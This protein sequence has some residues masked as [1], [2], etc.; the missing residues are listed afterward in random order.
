MRT[1]SVQTRKSKKISSRS[2]QKSHRLLQTVA[3]YSD[4]RLNQRDPPIGK[5]TAGGRESI[6]HRTIHSN[7]LKFLSGEGYIADLSF[8]DH[9]VLGFGDLAGGSIDGDGAGAAGV[10]HMQV[11]FGVTGGPFAAV[12]LNHLVYGV[13]HWACSG[14]KPP[15][16]ICTGRAHLHCLGFYRQGNGAEIGRAHV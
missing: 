14:K 7:A 4:L 1:P 10:I 5:V 2:A 11:L 8:D 13:L 15:L 16:G 12:L 3:F 6:Y 9:F